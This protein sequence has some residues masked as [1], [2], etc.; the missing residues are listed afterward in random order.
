MIF[1]VKG[2]S[3]ILILGA[4]ADDVEISMGGTLAK[5]CK[6]AYRS[7]GVDIHI[8]IFSIPHQETIIKENGAS[9]KEETKKALNLLS[10]N[11][12]K[13]QFYDFKVRRFDT[14]RQEIL[15][16]LV[17]NGKDIEPTMVFAPSLDDQHQDHS[18]LA[19]EAYRAFKNSSLFGYQMPWNSQ[20]ISR[21][22]FVKL[23][24]EHVDL[25]IK[26]LSMFKS[27]EKKFYI[28]PKFNENYL[29][30]MGATIAAD[31]AETFKIIRLVA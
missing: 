31:Y 23:E 12:A 19:H 11:T 28:R 22:M 18:V 17:Q 2:K 8:I 14:K 9:L 4:H 10:Y 21:S 13:L 26:A 7:D 5:M 6:N 15:D 30:A 24:K 27:Q 29:H 20:S 1:D 3:S 16:I 25:K